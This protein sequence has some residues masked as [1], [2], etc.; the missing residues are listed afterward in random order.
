MRPE[1]QGRID[2]GSVHTL[3]DLL[4]QGMEAE[5]LNKLKVSYR[6]PPDPD[7]FLYP[8]TAIKPNVPEKPAKAAAMPKVATM[9]QETD[10]ETDSL[11][12][13][14]K[15]VLENQDKMW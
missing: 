4:T 6:E 9:N 14:M 15:K 1:I 7:L 3:Q 10:T 8:D 11:C 5:M 2:R 12:M 13:L